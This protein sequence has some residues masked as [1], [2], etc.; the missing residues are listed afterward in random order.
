MES[1]GDAAMLNTKVMVKGLCCCLLI[2]CSI[3][4]VAQKKYTTD[5]GKIKFISNAEL[6]LIQAASDNLQGIIDPHSNQFAFT[7]QVQTFQG[8]NSE[9]Q[10]EHFNEKYIESEAYPRMAFSGK[11]IEVVDYDING[12]YEVRAKGE[13]SIH[14][15]KQTRIIKST[16]TIEDGSLSIESSF[17]VPLAD[18][19]IAVPRIVNQKIATEI[20]V[21]VNAVMSLH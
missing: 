13:L 3:Y 1:C 14:G 19:N 7:V 16:I 17:R 8:F 11:I 20:E 4:A 10:R 12:I 9:L 15:Q 2:F 5:R 18:H 21:T 6:E